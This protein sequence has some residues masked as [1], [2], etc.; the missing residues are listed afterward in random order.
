[1]RQPTLCPTYELGCI[2]SPINS[3][4]FSLFSYFKL[5]GSGANTPL[6]VKVCTCFVH[7]IF[8]SRLSLI[9]TFHQPRAFVFGKTSCTRGRKLSLS[10]HH[11][12][13]FVFPSDV[14]ATPSLGPRKTPE[15]RREGRQSRKRDGSVRHTACAGARFCASLY[16]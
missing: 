4:P 9:L 8:P 1:M 11:V 6:L 13:L 7:V 15:S 12:C 10:N 2:L 3:L 14:T 5:V 16:V